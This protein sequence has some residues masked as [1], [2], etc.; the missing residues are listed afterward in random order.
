M[1]FLILYLRQ[2]AHSRHI[3]LASFIVGGLLVLGFSPFNIW[4][5]GILCPALFLTLYFRQPPRRSF[6]VGLAFGLG[7]FGFGVSWVFI[8]IATYG[9]TN[10]GTALLITFLFVFGLSIYTA[11]HALCAN[12][13]FRLPLPIQALLVLPGLWTLFDYLRSTLFTGFS[14]MQLG[15]T[16]TF[17]WLGGY[18]K[19]F[20]VYGVTWLTAFLGGL[21][22]LVA[23]QFAFKRKTWTRPRQWAPT[24]ASLT[25]VC[26]ILIGGFAL[27]EY[28]FTKPEG[29][30]LAVA[31]VQGNI[32]QSIKWSPQALNNIMMTYAKLTGPYLATPLIVWPENAIPAFPETI[33]PFISALD[34]NLANLKSAI[35]LGLPIDN[36]V[37]HTYF[38]GALA[39]GNANGMYL[40]Q[41]LVPFGEYAP[42]G[43]TPLFNFLHIPMSS[44]SAGPK[45]VIPMEIHGLPVA[46]FI[47]YE[48]AYP[49]LVREDVGNAAYLITLTDDSWF[50]NSLGPR[51]HEEMEIMRSIETGR[52]I[53]RASNSGI[54]SI[55]DGHSHTIAR[56]PMFVPTVLTASIQ[57]VTGSTPWMRWGIT[58]F[59]IF[60]LLSLAIC[61]RV[62]YIK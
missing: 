45:E 24:F 49:R 13:L 34:T 21:L 14:W 58:P 25:L 9:N 22:V 55:I 50:G 31:L 26:F 48:S 56:A 12:T 39:L 17:T 40:K 38:N 19:C 2:I 42:L 3:Y 37:N 54:T 20:S 47:C 7:L 1:M 11:L 16:Q 6:L 43:L 8:S 27:R 46:V 51:Q 61:L 30:P 33:M 59:F 52:P 23:H 10:I 15:G 44:F 36:P 32:S 4:P 29:R 41:H 60:L 5:L 18:A 62:R 53:L 57:P 28:S 35:V